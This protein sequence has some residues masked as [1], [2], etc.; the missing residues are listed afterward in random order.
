MTIPV[1]VPV[2]L[3]AETHF[4]FFRLFPSLLYK[5]EPEVLFDMPRRLN[6]GLDLPIMLMCN[7]TQK[8]P[9][10]CLQ[11]Q[12]IVSNKQHERQQFTFDNPASFLI[13]HP[14]SATSDVYMFSI[15]RA[16]LG[17]GEFYITCTAQ[18]RKGRT[19]FTVINDNFTTSTHLP[20][21]CCC[22]AESLPG[23]EQCAY[24]DMHVHTQFSQ[25]QVE[26]GAPV[27]VVAVM[28]HAFGLQFTALTDHSYDLECSLNNY[29]T[30][31]TSHPRWT[32]LH[33]ESE[34]TDMPQLLLTGEE[35][36]CLNAAGNVIHLCCL[37]IID[38]ISGSADGARPK[39]LRGGTRKLAEVL[40]E[41]QRQ[42]G[43]AFAAH[44]G[45]KMGP[46]QRFFLNRGHWNPADY[47]QQLTGIQA[48]NDGFGKTWVRARHLWIHE[49]L[50]G[51]KLALVAGNDAHGDFNRY[52]FIS[53]PFISVAEND[54]RYFGCS[55]TG[56]YGNPATKQDC[57]NSLRDGK[58]F[59][60]SGPFIGITA[61]QTP[62][63]SLV[64]NEDH[65]QV[66][67]PA[68]TVHVGSSAEFGVPV[69]L[70]I[71]SGTYGAD[72][73]T[74]LFSQQFPANDSFHIS[75][76]VTLPRYNDKSYIRAE[77]QCRTAGGVV[78]Y[79]ATSPCYF[80]AYA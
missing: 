65:T 13:Q 40:C 37:G 66:D 14:L 30:G 18:L 8:F 25:S 1:P 2:F 64:S 29:F 4:R 24:G 76:D 46:L 51:H 20:F 56:I 54:S 23:T 33:K 57:M 26:F 34:R 41:V 17:D 47:M 36:S 12:I 52:R 79:A 11:I 62:N 43:I 68:I 39:L 5:K 42:N 73:E 6:P 19:T 27:E 31:D 69:Q 49:L 48:V 28:A 53:M 80:R 9:V 50:C 67:I 74:V 10:T 45:T 72:K 7:D 15:P 61:Q 59:I 78:H 21:I 75:K 35:V 55:R 63:V 60:T 22:A 3:Y 70:T 77:A 32:A 71:F 44:P 58:T 38:F 16:K